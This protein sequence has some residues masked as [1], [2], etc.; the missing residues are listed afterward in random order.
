M[1]WESSAKLPHPREIT[2]SSNCG[3]VTLEV[4]EP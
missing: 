1:A 3:P 2:K 4:Y